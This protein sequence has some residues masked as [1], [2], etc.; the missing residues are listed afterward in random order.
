MASSF[1]ATVMADVRRAAAGR[2]ASAPVK[3]AVAITI[4]DSSRSGLTVIRKTMPRR[5]APRVANDIH[6]IG[7]RLG[8]AAFADRS[9]RVILGPVVVAPM[10]AVTMRPAKAT[11]IHAARQPHT[12][13]ARY[14]PDRTAPARLAPP[15]RRSDRNPLSAAATC[16]VLRARRSCRSEIPSAA[17]APNTPIAHDTWRNRTSERTIMTILPGTGASARA[18]L[19]F[20]LSKLLQLCQVSNYFNY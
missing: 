20:D 11:S 8:P 13:A 4:N 18:G 19:A 14:M 5:M 3:V 16:S 12:V 7:S 10:I 6:R 1:H 17:S 2:L 15:R 9:R